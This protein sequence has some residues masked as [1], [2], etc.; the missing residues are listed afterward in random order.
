M[1]L[2][3]AVY[4]IAG[5]ALFAALLPFL[6]IYSRIT[7]RYRFYQ[8]ERLGLVP[9]AAVPPATRSPRIWIHAV[10]LGEIRAAAAVIRVLEETI[11]GVSMVLS[12][13]TEHGRDLAVET[14]GGKI[15]VIYAPVDVLFPV[16]CALSRIRP[17]IMVFLET[18]IW[19]AWLFFARRMG[20]RTALVNGRISGGSFGRYLRFRPFFRRVLG[21]FDALSMI[22]ERDAERI[23]AMGADPR[24]ITVNGNAKFDGVAALPDPRVASRIRQILNLVDSRPVFIAGSTREGEEKAVLDA[25]ERMLPAHPDMVL[26]LAPRHITRIREIIP[27]LTARGLAFQLRSNIGPSGRDP[28]ARVV[29]VDTFGELHHLY[30]VGTIIFCGGSLVP[31]GGQNVLEPAAW[32]K[33]VFH[34]P[35]MDNFLD[36]KALLEKARAGIRVSGPDELAEKALWYLEHREALD[37]AGRRARRAVLENSGAAR[38]HAEVIKR[39]AAR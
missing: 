22:R 39:L 35:H 14:F 21:N 2:L 30:S 32:G 16:R 1:N 36:A 33:A 8:C 3:Y 10:S 20:V 23:R 26:I 31:L 18:E 29:V 28:S 11:P 27:L 25:Y 19:P 5:G 34:G 9:R 6:W 17:D 24:R 13:M 7:G 12:T 15:P 38:R 4:L 37:A